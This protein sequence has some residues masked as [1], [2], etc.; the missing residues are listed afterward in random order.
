[1]KHGA[2]YCTH[3]YVGC[4]LNIATSSRSAQSLPLVRK[5]RIVRSVVDHLSM[6]GV[7]TRIVD[8]ESIVSVSPP[9]LESVVRDQLRVIGRDCY[10]VEPS[11]RSFCC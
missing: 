4:G 5:G 1:M 10:L 9:P 7:G 8:R 3:M 6:V 11:W 2:L